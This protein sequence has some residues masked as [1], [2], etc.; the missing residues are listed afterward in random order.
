M[1][2]LSLPLH[3]QLHTFGNFYQYK[4]CVKVSSIP[5]ETLLV[6]KINLSFSLT[7]ISLQQLLDNYSKSKAY[8]YC[9]S[10]WYILAGVVLLLVLFVLLVTGIKQS[11]LLDLAWSLTIVVLPYFPSTIKTSWGWAVPSS[12]QA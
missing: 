5:H 9:L 12:G 3:L 10:D 6:R 8:F 7:E 2:C 1:S 11:Q 4:V